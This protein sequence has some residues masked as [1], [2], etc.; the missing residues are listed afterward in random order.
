MALS[1]TE[2]TKAAVWASYIWGACI[3]IMNLLFRDMFPLLLQ[4]PINCGAF[5]MI[6][7]LIIVPVVSLLTPKKYK[8]DAEKVDQL[9][10]CYEKKNL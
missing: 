6:G 9:F 7:G 2:T 3:M 1:P 8:M 5:A 10:A 4:S